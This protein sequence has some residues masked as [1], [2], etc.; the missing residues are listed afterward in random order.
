MKELAVVL[1]VV[2]WLPIATQTTPA[3]AAVLAERLNADILASA[4]ATLTLEAW[5]RDHKMADD[6]K[7]SAPLVAGA[8]KAPTGEQLQRLQVGATSAVKYRRVEL[9]CGNHL[10]AEADNWYVP[11]RLTPEM[12]RLLETSDTP[13]GRVVQPLRPYRR[14]FASVRLWSFPS[15]TLFEHRA[16]LYTSDDEPFSEVDET[17]KAA[18]LN[19][20]LSR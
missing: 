10:F 3:D 5:C 7:I 8:P 18:L 4:S 13:F 19:V 17:Y 20:P 1:A 11:G 6:P 14:T 12:N 16:V 9:R 2:A 15:D